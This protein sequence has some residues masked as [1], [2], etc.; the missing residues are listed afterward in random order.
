MAKNLTTVTET[1]ATIPPQQQQ[2]R[3]QWRSQP[4]GSSNTCT[5]Q[6]R[7]PC[8]AHRHARF[9]VVARNTPRC[10]RERE[11]KRAPQSS[12]STGMRGRVRVRKWV[13]PRRRRGA[14]AVRARVR[15][16]A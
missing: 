6:E 1:D 11:R 15:A 7:K 9:R 5:S 14:A 8:R 12:R 2:S 13:V 16:R 3:S 4:N 10:V